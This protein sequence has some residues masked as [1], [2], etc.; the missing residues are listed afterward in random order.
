MKVLEL[1]LTVLLGIDSESSQVI[2]TSLTK[3]D[4]L[5]IFRDKTLSDINGCNSIQ[6]I[7]KFSYYPRTYK[8]NKSESMGSQ[9]G[10]CRSETYYIITF[11]QMT[12]ALR[13]RIIHERNCNMTMEMSFLSHSL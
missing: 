4:D 9:P 8:K 12:P 10:P 5:N 13:F 11:Y 1:N 6:L 3:T 2:N 7:L